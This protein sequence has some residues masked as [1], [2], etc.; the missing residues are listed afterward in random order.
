VSWFLPAAT[1]SSHMDRARDR[2][3][4]SAYSFDH[5]ISAYVPLKKVI[6]CCIIFSSDLF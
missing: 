3:Q 6:P 2:P 4:R 1:I 5:Y